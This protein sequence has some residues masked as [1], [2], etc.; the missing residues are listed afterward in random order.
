MR[1]DLLEV[2]SLRLFKIAWLLK[3]PSLGLFEILKKLKV[4]RM[5]FM[6]TK[7]AHIILLSNNYLR[8]PWLSSASAR[9]LT[10][11]M[12][13]SLYPRN[14]SRRKRP[15][16]SPK[17][18]LLSG[19]SVTSKILIFNFRRV[20]GLNRKK[21]YSKENST[22]YSSG[23]HTVVEIYQHSIICAHNWVFILLQSAHFI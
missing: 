23:G 11:P 17:H 15:K 12:M 3:N 9:A 1:F 20:A 6:A 13:K 22:M 7:L 14:S 18:V 19:L 16:L 4:V 2:D 10:A 8:Y 21:P 5:L